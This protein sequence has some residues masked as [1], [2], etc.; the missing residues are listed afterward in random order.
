M[1]AQTTVITQLYSMCLSSP[2]LGP[3]GY[4]G[5]A[6][7]KIIA[8]NSST[9]QNVQALYMLVLPPHL[10]NSLSPNRPQDQARIQVKR[11][12]K[13]IRQMVW[14]WRGVWRFS[15]TIVTSHLKLFMLL[16]HCKV[17]LPLFQKPQLFHLP[18]ISITAQECVIY[19][20][21]MHS[22]SWCGD[23]GTK[24]TR[25]YPKQTTVVN[26]WLIVKTSYWKYRR[27]ADT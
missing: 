13:F 5:N 27:I 14:W 20:R 9:S 6:D 24:R 22:F 17:L 16:P 15:Y 1:V 23:Q 7:L 2:F 11:H 10:A 26:C 19:I 12:S 4:L 8:E 21:Y 25:Y 18:P 3:L